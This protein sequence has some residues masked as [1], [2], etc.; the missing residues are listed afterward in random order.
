M[1]RIVHSTKS[2]ILYSHQWLAQQPPESAQAL[3]RSTHWRR[4]DCIFT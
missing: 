2:M 1:V 3:C 4:G